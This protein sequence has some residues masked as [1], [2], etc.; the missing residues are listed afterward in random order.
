[1]NREAVS[2]RLQPPL[3]PP[4]PVPGCSRCTRLAEQRT[5]AAAKGDHSRVSDC[6]VRLRGHDHD[7]KSPIPS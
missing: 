3:T 4:E 7:T 1:M 5:A 6:N 2:Y